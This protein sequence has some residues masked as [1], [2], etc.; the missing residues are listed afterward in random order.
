MFDVDVAVLSTLRLVG[1]SVTPEM[2]GK[3]VLA[4]L[5]ANAV[6]RL[7]LGIAAG[8]VRFWLP[9]A[10]ATAAAIGLGVAA[11]AFMPLL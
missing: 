4:A 8:S 3:A 11:F 2:A 1:Q 7:A 9:L 10:A 6:G 5:A